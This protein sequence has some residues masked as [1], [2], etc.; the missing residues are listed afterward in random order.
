MKDYIF[1]WSGL[2]WVC[3]NT[4]V[5]IETISAVVL[6]YLSELGFNANISPPP[7]RWGLRTYNSGLSIAVLTISSLSKLHKP[8]KHFRN[9]AT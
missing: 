2:V 7:S 6:I 1:N 9:V 8:A 3:T 5:G 4:L